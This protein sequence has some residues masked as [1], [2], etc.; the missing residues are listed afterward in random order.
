MWR[1]QTSNHLGPRPPP[2]PQQTP[3]WEAELSSV[4]FLQ[5]PVAQAQVQTL[6]QPHLWNGTGAKIICC[7][8][9]WKERWMWRHRKVDKAFLN[10]KFSKP[11]YHS[12]SFWLLC[13]AIQLAAEVSPIFEFDFSIYWCVYVWVYSVLVCKWVHTDTSDEFSTTGFILFSIF[14]FP[15]LELSLRVRNLALPI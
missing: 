1:W 2:C 7:P 6:L 5:N 9:E 15:S 11:C 12:E 14:P 3:L 8:W 4:F 13:S 10:V